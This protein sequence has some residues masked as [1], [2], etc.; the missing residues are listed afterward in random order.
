MPVNQL[1]PFFCFL[2][3]CGLPTPLLSLNLVSSMCLIFFLCILFFGIRSRHLDASDFLCEHTPRNFGAQ[4]VTHIYIRTGAHTCTYS[5]LIDS[6]T[7]LLE[8][9]RQTKNKNKCSSKTQRRCAL[10]QVQAR[11]F[12]FYTCRV[13][14][15]SY[16]CDVDTPSNALRTAVC[17]L[18]PKKRKEIA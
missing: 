6:F 4:D 10:I 7:H 12:F 14:V 2:W 1:G 17:T 11:L 13:L 5:G 16:G 15:Q 3:R 18:T 9:L 8:N